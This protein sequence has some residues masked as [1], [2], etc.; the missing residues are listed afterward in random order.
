MAGGARQTSRQESRQTNRSQPCVGDTDRRSF[1]PL[2][3]QCNHHRSRRVARHDRDGPRHRHVDDQL[4]SHRADARLRCRGSRVRQGRRPVGAQETVPARP[5][6]RVDICRFDRR[7]VERDD[8]DPLPHPVGDGRFGHGSGRD[9]VHQPHVRTR[10]TRAPA[11]V[12]EL[13]HRGGARSRCGSRRADRRDGGL[14]RDLRR[15]GSASRARVA[16]R[17]ALVARNRAATQRQVRPPR[18]GGSRPRR[19]IDVARHQP[20]TLVGLGER[21]RHR[22]ARRR[23]VR[24]VVLLPCRARRRGATASDALAAYAQRGVSDAQP[25]AHQLRLHGRLLRRA[26]VVGKRPRLFDVPHRVADHRATPH[27]FGRGRRREH[28]HVAHR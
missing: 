21:T 7:R 19:D 23:C 20:W 6:R 11:R 2:R 13:H 9:G 1:R 28:H 3:G 17:M 4:G 25:G 18:F 16:D 14:A 15:S 10:G 5:A 27:V 24:P 22:V 12:L 8:D 26:A